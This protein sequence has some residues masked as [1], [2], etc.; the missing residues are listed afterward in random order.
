M[1]NKDQAQFPADTDIRAAGPV[2]TNTP[3]LMNTLLIPWDTTCM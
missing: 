2:T 1:Y 3:V